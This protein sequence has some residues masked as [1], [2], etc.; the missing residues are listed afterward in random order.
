MLRFIP[1]QKEPERIYDRLK[2]KYEGQLTLY[3]YAMGKIFGVSPDSVKTML[4]NIYAGFPLSN[5][6]SGK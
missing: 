1:K 2:A 4:C 5:V 6:K 3:R